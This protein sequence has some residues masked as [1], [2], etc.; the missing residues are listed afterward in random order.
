M[1][2]KLLIA[3]G[4]I[5]G[6]AAALA[7]ARAGWHVQLIE[8]A[9]VFNEIGAGIQLGPNVT[10]R[11][12]AWGL[13]AALQEVAAFPD[14]LLARDA[15]DGRQLG[16]MQLGERAQKR[17]GAPYATIHRADMHQ[18]LANAAQAEANVQ[19]HMGL[20][21][22]R[23]QEAGDAAQATC[24]DGQTLQ[25]DAFVG[26]DGLWGV[27]RRAVLGEEEGAIAPR[28]SGHLA[29]RAMLDQARLP[30]ALRSQ[31]VTLW[32][33]PR[34]HAV[35]YPVRGGQWMNLVVITEGKPPANP[36]GWDHQANAYELMARMNHVCAPLRELLLAAPQ[37]TLNPYVWRLWPLC[38]RPPVPS[39]AHMARGRMALLGDAAHPTRPYLAQGAGMAV[40]DADTLGRCLREA[41]TATD[42]TAVPQQLAR[43]ARERWARCARIQARSARNGAIYHASG[44]LRQAR[45]TAL[46]A[47]G[48]RLMDMPWLYS[49]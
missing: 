29:W 12:H 37:A 9:C 43:Y 27:A 30:A 33:G 40:E 36:R 18:L 14:A 13:Q 2:K 15:T 32:M 16:S 22:E 1:S 24:D 47:L 4:G 46:R 11:L 8:R 6:M 19:I 49:H 41:A 35:Q 39:A 21:L 5:G 3:G 20:T 48:T 34:L 31:C 42:A 17:Y 10:K 45:N 26:A 28:A 25:A 38:D 44:L 7:T 23:A